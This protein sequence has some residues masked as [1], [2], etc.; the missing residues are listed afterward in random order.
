MNLYTLILIFLW[1][2]IG[3]LI[4]GVFVLVFMYGR[5]TVKDNPNKA[6]IF[7]KTGKHVSK[8][9]KGYLVGQPS[10]SGC[11]YK[12]DNHDVFVPNKYGDI[13]YCS[14]RM[15]FINRIGQLVPMPFDDDV[16]MTDNEKAE[17]IYELCASHIGADSIKALKGKQSFNIILVG[18]IA[19]VFGI[20]AVVG[21]SYMS[22][23]LA[24]Q[25]SPN[26]PSTTQEKPVEVK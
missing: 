7:I 12:Y 25:Q 9:I 26:K 24:Q 22:D 1:A 20:L 3:L 23:T 11:R 18:V 16:S 21:Y 6:L 5:L 13:F 15:L 4:I 19:F 8:P 10:S 2:F 17:L 14:K